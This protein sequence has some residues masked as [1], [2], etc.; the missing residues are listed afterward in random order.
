MKNFK[1]LDKLLPH[2][3]AA[4][5][6]FYDA[7][8]KDSRLAVFFRDNEQILNL[9]KSQKVHLIKS[10]DMSIDEL[11]SNYIKL[12]EYHYDIRIP[13]IDFMK[14]TEILQEYFLLHIQESATESELMIE[15]FEYF[16]IM[17]AFTA[18]GYLNKMLQEDKKRYRK[19]F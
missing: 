13:Y 1:H 3:D 10:L 7:M 8:L 5:R 6:S 14:G 17:K 11:K 4:F 9:I 15:I 18:K 19:L 12:G 16:K 2:M